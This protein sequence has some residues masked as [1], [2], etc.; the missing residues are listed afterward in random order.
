MAVYAIWNNK[1]GVGKSYLSFQIASEYARTH[2]DRRVLVIDLCPQANASGML[3]GGMES[4][5]VALDSL[6]GQAPRRTIAGNIEDR[7]LSP[8]V[9]PGTG[10]NY[11]IRVSQMNSAIP[12]NLYLVPGDEQLEMQM[13]RSF[14]TRTA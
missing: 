13:V 11:L 8:Y 6:S 4:G 7:I 2:P 12:S 10:S 14:C 9:N 5:E 1:G 3:L